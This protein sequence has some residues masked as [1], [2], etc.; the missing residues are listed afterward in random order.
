MTKLCAALLVAAVVWAGEPVFYEVRFP[1]AVHHEAE[2]AVRFPAVRQPV[3]EVRMS[4]SSPGRYA[5][6]EFAKNVYRVRAEDAAGTPLE[7]TRPNPHQW[8]VTGHDGTVTF[9]YTLYGDRV[10]G[11]YAAIDESHAHLNAPAAFVWARGFETRPVR[12]RFHPPEE[13]GWKVA[14]QLKPAAEPNV[15]TA[16]GLDRLLDSPVEL[17]RF[18]TREW[19]VSDQTIRLVVHHLGDDN[20]VTGY[21]EKLKK[22]VREQVAIFGALPDFDH[23]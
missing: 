20:A 10:D 14:T 21:A 16:P 23:G 22:V 2:V 19:K 13:L 18:S 1:N 17:S 5:L 7:I 9:R 6:H 15:F 4:R 3:L 12:V 11:T 8:N